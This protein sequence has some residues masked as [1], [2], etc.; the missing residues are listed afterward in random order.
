MKFLIMHCAELLTY[1]NLLTSR[2]APMNFDSKYLYFTSFP[3][4]K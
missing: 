4:S 2:Y 1:F 3:P